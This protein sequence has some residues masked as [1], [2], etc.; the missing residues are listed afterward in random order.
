MA[1][2]IGE[3]EVVFAM[4]NV[5]MS[6]SWGEQ[7]NSIGMPFGN[8]IGIKS[9]PMMNWYSSMSRSN[10]SKMCGGKVGACCMEANIMTGVTVSGEVRPSEGWE[11]E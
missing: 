3:G 11:M 7:T 9:F 5:M 10:I 8:N 4:D 6:E 1:R 2:S